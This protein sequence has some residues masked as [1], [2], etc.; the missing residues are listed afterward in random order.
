MERKESV[1][2]GPFEREIVAGS[3][4]RGTQRPTGLKA[5]S[6]DRLVSRSRFLPR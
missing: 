2:L 5:I 1:G 4:G 3:I 6:L